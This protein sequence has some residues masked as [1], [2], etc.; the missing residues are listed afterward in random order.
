[1]L[2]LTWWIQE[3][4]TWYFQSI[5]MTWPLWVL[6]SWVESVVALTFV[7]LD[8]ITPLHSYVQCCCCCPP[9]TPTITDILLVR[10]S[11]WEPIN[12]RHDLRSQTLTNCHNVIL[13]RESSR[14]AC[15]ALRQCDSG[16]EGQWDPSNC[17]CSNK[18][19]PSL[20]RT[21]RTKSLPL[22]MFS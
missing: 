9:Q 17:N 14:L 6:H 15:G 20:Y 11:H 13:Y 8:F 7:T 1:M 18:P 12:C 16:M 5:I 2:G 22:F 4:F 3:D 10:S 21:K 19:F